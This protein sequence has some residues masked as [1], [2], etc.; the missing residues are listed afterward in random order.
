VVVQQYRRV[1]LSRIGKLEHSAVSQLE[2]L[3][4]DSHPGHPLD[5]NIFAVQRHT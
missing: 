5:V 1:A 4:L 3:I 2:V